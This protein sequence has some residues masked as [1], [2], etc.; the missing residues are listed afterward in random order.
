MHRDLGEDGSLQSTKKDGEERLH[1]R[2]KKPETKD[3]IGLPHKS[4]CSSDRSEVKYN[5]ICQIQLL[6]TKHD[7]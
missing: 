7:R 1:K 4:R 6:A 3:T 5:R 2:I